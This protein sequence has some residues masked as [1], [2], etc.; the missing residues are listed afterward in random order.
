MGA[1]RLVEDGRTG[2]VVPAGAPD[3]L[4]QALGTL[5]RDTATRRTYGAAAQDAA[6]AFTYPHVGAQRA[7]LL[8]AVLRSRGA[9]AA[10]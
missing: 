5:A 9:T 7:A 4:A 1:A 8:R 10:A 6:S 2:L 3:R